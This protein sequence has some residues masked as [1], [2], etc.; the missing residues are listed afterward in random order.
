MLLLALGGEACKAI[1][2]ALEPG[3]P[4]REPRQRA[5]GSRKPSPNVTLTFAELCVSA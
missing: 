3:R 4:L 1:T 5:S 2:A